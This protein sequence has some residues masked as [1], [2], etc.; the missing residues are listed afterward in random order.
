MNH[1]QSGERDDAFLWLERARAAR[2]SWLT[3]LGIDPV[4]DP[5]RDEPRFEE[6][7][8]SVNVRR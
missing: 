5:L 2:R 3:E 4:S 6:L 1:A 8:R 7:E